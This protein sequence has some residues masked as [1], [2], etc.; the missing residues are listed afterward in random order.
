[1]K[2]T[3]DKLIGAFVCVIICLVL[4]NVIGPTNLIIAGIGLYACKAI[5]K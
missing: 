3:L 2:K 5:V 1:M 4:V